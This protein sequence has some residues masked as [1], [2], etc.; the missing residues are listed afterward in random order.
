MN[1]RQ[2]MASCCSSSSCISLTGQSPLSL[3]RQW[4]YKEVVKAEDILDRDIQDCPI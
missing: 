1:G 3:A 4:A 2:R